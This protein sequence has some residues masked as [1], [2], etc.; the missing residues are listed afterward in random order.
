MPRFIVFQRKIGFSF[1]LYTVGLRTPLG[2]SE[3]IILL[4]CIIT[5][6]SVLQPGVFLAAT[7]ICRI[8]YMYNNCCN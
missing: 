4:L 8:I 3:T 6:R 1:V 2:Q 7:A 5:S